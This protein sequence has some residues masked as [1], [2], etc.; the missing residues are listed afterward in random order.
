MSHKV[1]NKQ[2]NIFFLKIKKSAPQVPL[3]LSEQNHIL[4]HGTLT[5]QHPK[6][7]STT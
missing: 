3:Y 6:E 1:I 7:A 4:T 5:V 2:L